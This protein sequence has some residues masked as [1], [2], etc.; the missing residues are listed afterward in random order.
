MKTNDIV[1]VAD[2]MNFKKEIIE[3][4]AVI[5]QPKAQAKFVNGKVLSEVTGVKSY[6]S[7]M[8]Y[9]GQFSR[10]VGGRNFFDLDAVTQHLKS[11]Q[12][13]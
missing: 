4:I 6:N 12:N 13:D 10:K 7:L 8:K 1:T 2:L 11:K 9:F 3:Q 5:P